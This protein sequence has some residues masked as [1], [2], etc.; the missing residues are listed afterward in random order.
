M[1][2]VN[3]YGL[4]HFFYHRRINLTR[5]K[6]GT[7]VEDVLNFRTIEHLLPPG[8]REETVTVI[9]MRPD[10][11]SRR[12]YRL[13]GPGDRSLVAILPPAGDENG[14]A[15]AR[16]GWR[17]GTHLHRL[18]CSVPRMHG[19][20]PATGTLLVED[21]GDTRL[22]GLLRDRDDEAR[23]F[24][25]RRVVRELAWMQVQGGKGLSPGWC[26]DTPLYDQSV[27]IE[28]ESGYFLRALCRDLLGLSWDEAG[29][30]QEC[31]R[32]AGEAALAPASYFLHRD[33]Q[34]RNLMVKGE[35]VVIIDYQ[36]GR[37][38]PL[39]YDL[40]ALLLD[41]Y[42]GLS[43]SLQQRVYR[44]YLHHL[45]SL[46]GY[47]PRRFAREYHLLALQRNLQILGAFAFLWHRRGK[48]F[49]AAF[50]QPALNSLL[51]LLARE[52][53]GGYP[54]LRELAERCL[55]SPRL[56]RPN[57]GDNSHG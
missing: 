49:F 2:E 19:F 15:E 27:M 38:G 41:P 47:D 35:R 1:V 18:G 30:E 46:T 22:H 39:A 3:E 4:T 44:E 56:P 8:W 32:L 20:D 28:R 5:E 12:L 42:M 55:A 31:R 37:R 53:G 21:L 23:F 36:G 7:I 57:P 33:F 9:A 43:S 51:S 48:P 25:Y 54:V 14:M 13:T 17:I 6:G 40:A 50:L 16:S 26:W 24:W 52:R 11:S 10:G 45:Q 29:V 34:S